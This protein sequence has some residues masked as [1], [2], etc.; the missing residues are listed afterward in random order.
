MIHSPAKTNL[1][2][3]PKLVRNGGHYFPGVPSITTR[4][5]QEEK[6][7][8]P[9]LSITEEEALNQIYHCFEQMFHPKDGREKKAG[10]EELWRN[11]FLFS[12]GDERTRLVKGGSL[13]S[14]GIVE[15]REKTHVVFK[16]TH[17]GV[18]WKIIPRSEFV[19]SEGFDGCFTKNDDWIMDQ[20]SMVNQREQFGSFLDIAKETPEYLLWA[21]FS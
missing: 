18:L 7:T 10:E 1:L 2:S 15:F 9:G 5:Q 17:F 12:D 20:M 8:L 4:G 14:K 19:C 16:D 3:P 21:T 13:F 11:E 6:L